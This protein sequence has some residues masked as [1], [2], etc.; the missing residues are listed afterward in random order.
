M[1][2]LK[3]IPNVPEFKPAFI[4]KYKTLTDWE[5]Y[6]KFT[7]SFLTKSIRVNTLKADTADIVKRM[8]KN[9][10]LKQIPWCAEG[11][12]LEHKEGRLDVGNTHEH[13]LGYYY[14]QEAASMIP[15][16]VLNP[17]PGDTVLDI[18]AAPGSKTTQMAAMMKNKGI[19][20]ANDIASDRLAALG[21]N[22]QRTGA[23]NIVMTQM[24]GEGIRGQYDKVLL[25]APCSGTGT[26]RKSIKTITMWNPESIK[27]ISGL[28]KKLIL[29]AYKLT[30]DVLVYSTCSTEPEEDEEVISF[31]LENTDAKVEKIELNIKHG[32]AI[33]KYGKKEYNPEVAKCLRVFPQDNDTEGFFV[34]KIRRPN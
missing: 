23:S 2:E 4:E 31:L 21:M 13:Q 15:P 34:A 7:L 22:V 26:I 9:W 11:F 5:E 14:V 20:V 12:W 32:P 17:Q 25:D 24:N 19:I 10:N 33:M 1:F 28:Q 16:M 3:P 27:K 30:K 6:K 29:N 8:S 18:A